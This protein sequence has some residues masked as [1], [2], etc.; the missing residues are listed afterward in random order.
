MWILILGHLSRICCKNGDFLRS[1]FLRFS[2]GSLVVSVGFSPGTS[3][4]SRLW[5]GPPSTT[6]CTRARPPPATATTTAATPRFQFLAAPVLRPPRTSAARRW[7][8]SMSTV[9]WLRRCVSVCVR[10]KETH[11][12]CQIFTGNISWLKVLK[13]LIST[14]YILL[15]F[16]AVFAH[17]VSKQK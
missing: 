4:A 8:T 9:N 7:D 1:L 14:L 3:R 6:P 11:C 12:F 13:Y 5:R 16:L 2:S 17:L 15:I 10:E